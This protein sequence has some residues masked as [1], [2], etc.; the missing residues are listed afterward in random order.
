MLK[1]IL[2]TSSIMAIVASG[3]AF[4][5]ATPYIGAGLGVTVNTANAKALGNGVTFGA[6]RGMP[7][8]VFAGYG[9]VIDQN[10]YLAGEVFGTPGTVNLSYNNVLKTSWGFGASLLPGVMIS[11]HTMAYARVGVIRSHFTYDSNR[12]GGQFGLGLQTSLT[13]NID[14][15][16][17]YDYN[18]YKSITGYV[19]G[20][21][22][23]ISPRSDQFNVG[24]IYKFE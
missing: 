17:E 16:G 22:V 24:I 11:D 23:S 2:V 10:F 9:G 12:T 3:T 6:Y 7:F 5:N 18:V 4:A 20:T 15:R 8:T 13:Q 19:G 21:S 14:L 1:K